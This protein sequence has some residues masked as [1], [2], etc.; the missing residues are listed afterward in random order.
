MWRIRSHLELECHQEFETRDDALIEMHRM[1]D[2][3]ADCMGDNVFHDDIGLSTV[4]DDET[5]DY[6]CYWLTYD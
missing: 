1:A 2:D 5:D 4:W 6:V 3:L